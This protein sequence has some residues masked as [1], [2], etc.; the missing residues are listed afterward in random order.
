MDF[1][2]E[3]LERLKKLSHIECSPEEEVA[4][5]KKLNSTLHQIDEI[6]AV[7]VAGVPECYSVVEEAE[8]ILRDDEVGELLSNEELLSN[9][10]DK[11]GGMI[12]TPPVIVNYVP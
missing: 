8:N 2:R 7:D 6:L 11:V 1:S 5:I 12:R 3:D 9:A 4:L 10:P